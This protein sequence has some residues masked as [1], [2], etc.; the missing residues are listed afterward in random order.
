MDFH[1]LQLSAREKFNGAC[2]VC[3]VCNG[4]ACAGQVPGMGGLGTGAAF[5]AN[6]NAL[7]ECRLNLRTVHGV[8]EPRMSCRILGL[9]LALPIFA[10]PIAG[11]AMNMKGA[12]AEEDY[13]RAVVQG[14]RQA[15]VL[16]MTGDGPKPEIFAAGIGAMGGG[17]A[18]PVVKPRENRKIIELAQTAQKAGAPAFGMDIDAAAL[19]NMTNA[20]QP[21]GPKTLEDLRYIKEN[22]SIPFIVKGIMTPDEAEACM[23]AGV[24]A[25]VVSNHGGRAL[26]HTPG[27]A[28]VLPYIAEI[29]DGRM[30]ILVDGGVRSGGDILK[31]LALGADGVLI[32]RPVAVGAIGG[33]AE[34]VALV[35]NKMAAELRAAMILTGVADVAAVPPEILW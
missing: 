22:A 2:R 12:V 28:E 16:A 5:C 23:E 15:G 29:A 14:C 33:G 26:D 17:P 25:V 3:P 10:A 35:L 8:K 31:M 34:G 6:V 18:I 13:D 24:D 30:T 27:T 11:I 4:K 32:G 21:V 7:A 1:N 20:G 19:V 9:E